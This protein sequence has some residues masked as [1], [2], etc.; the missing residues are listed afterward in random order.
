MRLQLLLE[1]VAARGLGSVATIVE[2]PQLS[3]D[4]A[5]YVPKDAA[6]WLIASTERSSQVRRQR[7][8]QDKDPASL[9]LVAKLADRERVVIER[10]R[11]ALARPR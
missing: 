2:G 3:P 10:L 8:A 11:R 7:A 9:A 4:M 1:D 6:V 5:D